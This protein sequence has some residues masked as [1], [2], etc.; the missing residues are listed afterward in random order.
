MRARSLVWVAVLWCFCGIFLGVLFQRFLAKESFFPKAGKNSSKSE[1]LETKSV[2]PRSG[3]EIPRGVQGNLDL[4]ILAGQSNMSGYG[5]IKVEEVETVPRAFLFGNDYRWRQAR[6][7][8]DDPTGQVD[9][10]SQDTEAGYSCGTSFAKAFLKNYPN[11]FV[12]L[13]PCAKGGSPIEEW[14]RNLSEHSLYGSCLK[15]AL[16][17]SSMGKIRGLL[18][19]Q[20]ETD[21]LG[22]DFETQR[23][24]NPFQWKKKFS[25]FVSDFR[26]DLRIQD[27]PVVFAQIGSNKD[28][29]AF[30]NWKVVQEEQRN[31]HLPNCRMIR[32]EDLALRD[33]VHFDSAGYR[34]IGER[35]ASAITEILK[36]QAKH[37]K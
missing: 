9:Q 34:I 17:A 36:E 27:L 26:K 10:V 7:P 24:K 18:F 1:I 23:V 28:P 2:K 25:T 16:A 11:S 29:G 8:V 14:Q 5:E 20:G 13:I 35:F 21:A 22:P 31:V 37:S 32:T 33:V 6:E 15:R 30:R 12:G 19:F 4:F 3:V